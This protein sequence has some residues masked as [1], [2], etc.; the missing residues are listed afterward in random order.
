M[1][2]VDK[3]EASDTDQNDRPAQDAVIEKVALSD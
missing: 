1:D 3:I 2:V